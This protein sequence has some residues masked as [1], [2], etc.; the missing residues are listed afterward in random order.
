MGIYSHVCHEYHLLSERPF[1]DNAMAELNTKANAAIEQFEESEELEHQ[2][3]E[4]P[5]APEH[6]KHG[7]F[8]GKL[9][10]MDSKE[11]IK[12]AILGKRGLGA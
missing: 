9:F 10:G 11:F 12:C 4:K 6:Y 7:D 3:H 8:Q 1:G 5:E 2:A